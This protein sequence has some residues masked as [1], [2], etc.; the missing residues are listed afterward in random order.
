VER[1]FEKRLFTG[2]DLIMLMDDIGVGYGAT[3]HTVEQ[4]EL[5]RERHP[6]TYKALEGPEVEKK[7]D[8]LQAAVDRVR[9]LV[10][11]ELANG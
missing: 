11:E 10:E 3:I 2:R 1:S 6:D 4:A 8:R 9:A 7:L 5:R